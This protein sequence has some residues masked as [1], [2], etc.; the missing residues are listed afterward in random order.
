MALGRVSK[1][2][3]EL[4]TDLTAYVV[5]ET[6]TV[7]SP[8]GGDSLVCTVVSIGDGVLD[9]V[10]SIVDLEITHAGTGFESN[11]SNG[12]VYYVPVTSGTG[13]GVSIIVVAT[14]DSD[15]F[16]V[17]FDAIG[18]SALD[19]SY[20]WNY[21]GYVPPSNG[22]TALSVQLGISSD[23]QDLR[24]AG[25]HRW[26]LLSSLL[27]GNGIEVLDIVNSDSVLD[28]ETPFD[29]NIELNLS[30]FEFDIRVSNSSPL[31]TYAMEHNSV[32]NVPET[33]QTLIYS[34]DGIPSNDGEINIDGYPIVLSAST[35]TTP[36]LIG[37]A[38]VTELLNGVT[39]G[40][41]ESVVNVS[42][43][44]TVVY[45]TVN[46]VSVAPFFDG[47]K[48]ERERVKETGVIVSTVFNRGIPASIDVSATVMPIIVDL[49]Q[50]S[51]SNNLSDYIVNKVHEVSGKDQF[52]DPS[53]GPVDWFAHSYYDPTFSSVGVTSVATL[54]AI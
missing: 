34:V 38:I 42:G 32:I 52:Q 18:A 51:L 7:A 20:F 19:D 36:E 3:C 50:D 4:T 2:K 28:K 31:V 39:V 6:L 47:Y 29:P 46:Y 24:N 30:G 44:V 23:N 33:K 45:N 16:R 21:G 26:M 54:T 14:I 11:N 13:V 5:G 10:G 27:A 41:Y 15:D 48:L 49:I 35:H 9:E 53:I 17:S 1:I 12:N 40:R 25:K 22:R 8:T 37:D 43:V